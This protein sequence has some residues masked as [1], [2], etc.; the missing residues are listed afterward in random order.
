MKCHHSIDDSLASQTPR[1]I[2]PSL[3]LGHVPPKHLCTMHPLAYSSHL[4]DLALLH[5]GKFALDARR[6]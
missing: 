5:E 3:S 1:L 2:N 4:L 6:D